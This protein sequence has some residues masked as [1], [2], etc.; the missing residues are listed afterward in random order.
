MTPKTRH[1]FWRSV[2]AFLLLALAFSPVNGPA[3]RA[4]AGTV[5]RVSVDSNEAQANAIS[6]KG[7]IS[8]DSRFVA[9]DSEATNLVPVDMNN[10]GDVF[11]RDLLLGTTS[12]ASTTTAGAQANGGSGNP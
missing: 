4:Q 5:T 6:Y 12:L 3:V 7:D 11:L 9:F 8:A 2:S 1:F 10:N